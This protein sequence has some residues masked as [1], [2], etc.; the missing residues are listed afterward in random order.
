MARRRCD[1][2]VAKSSGM[3]FKCVDT[4]SE[5]RTLRGLETG[6]GLPL[7]T[8]R[9]VLAGGLGW[10]VGAETFHVIDGRRD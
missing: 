10:A 9:D 3:K 8:R 7:H 6:V 5:T 2:L 4:V 1:E